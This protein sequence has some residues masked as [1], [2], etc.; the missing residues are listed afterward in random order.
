MNTS[1]RADSESIQKQE[2]ERCRSM[3]PF[4]T[5]SHDLLNRLTFS[6]SFVPQIEITITWTDS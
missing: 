1:L 6:K 5:S 2:C 3:I 4:T